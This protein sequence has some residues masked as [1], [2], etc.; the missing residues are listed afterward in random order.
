[1]SNQKDEMNCVLEEICETQKPIK[2]KPKGH[3]AM[4][5]EYWDR[6]LECRCIPDW[7]NDAIRAGA[8]P[9]DVM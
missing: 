7:V 9:E 5:H 8:K 2:T 6:G 3:T 4:C 1:M